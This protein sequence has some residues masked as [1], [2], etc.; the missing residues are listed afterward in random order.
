MVSCV[1]AVPALAQHPARGPEPRA[2]E[3]RVI[4]P[5]LSIAETY[6][7][8]FGVM[9]S[10]V[11]LG[12]AIAPASQATLSLLDASGKIL[13]TEK[14]AVKS[15]TVR[16]SVQVVFT[17]GRRPWAANRF[18]VVV[19]SG[20]SVKESS[21]TN[22]A[23]A[24]LDAPGGSGRETT[25]AISVSPKPGS[26][27]VDLAAINVFLA[28]DGFNGVVRNVGKQAYTGERQATILLARRKN[29]KLV[30]QKLGSQKIGNLSP[31]AQQ[32]VTV[33]TPSGFDQSDPY[34]LTLVVSAGDGNASNDTKLQPSP[35]F[36]E[37]G[38]STVDLEAVDVL[39]LL[40]AGV[41][42][43]KGTVRNVGSDAFEGDRLVEVY[44]VDQSGDK[45]ETTLITSKKIKALANGE[46]WEIT[47][48]FPDS[49]RK[50]QRFLLKLVVSPGDDNEAN[51]QKVRA[52]GNL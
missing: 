43:V 30:E 35:D 19:D 49:L 10:I 48:K 20:S 44:F 25:P 17:A 16:E 1:L 11:N 29:G 42:S 18:R 5:D 45:P 32:S 33:A 34:R 6:P 46:D 24:M 50:I 37:G 39:K 7:K 2:P 22:N 41:V 9:V 40:E 13:W 31:G 38:S 26:S 27:T 23:T 12:S 8:D 3:G 28:N 21:E 52:F 4:L 47:A 51:D 36:E 14:Q 15:L